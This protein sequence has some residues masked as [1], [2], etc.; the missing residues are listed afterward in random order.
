MKRMSVF[1]DQIQPLDERGRVQAAG[2]TS[3]SPQNSGDQ[4]K[5]ASK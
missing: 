4:K 1:G 2:K 5:A 3:V